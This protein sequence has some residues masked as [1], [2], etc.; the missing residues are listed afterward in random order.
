MF[1][2]QIQSS[3]AIAD[4]KTN[5]ISDYIEVEAGV[6]YVLSGYTGNVAENNIRICLYGADKSQIGSIR[7]LP[8]YNAN[9]PFEG[10]F[11]VPENGKYT[12]FTV[13]IA[14]SDVM[15]ERG[16]AQDGSDTRT[17]YEPYWDESWQT[18]FVVDLLAVGDDHKDDQD[19]VNGAVHRRTAACRYDGTQ[20]IGNEYMST[21]GGKDIGA[22]IVYP[23]DLAADSVTPQPLTLWEGTNQIDSAAHVGPLTAQIKY[24][25][26]R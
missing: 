7:R 21:T 12:R 6:R 25:E 1:G 5:L 24:M 14:C 9:L 15:L 4:L 3:G 18:A 8:N 17:E 23:T 2:K 16:S 19:L 22:I 11:A 20:T 13:P 26:R 10:S